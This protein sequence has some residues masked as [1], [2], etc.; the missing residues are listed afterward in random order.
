MT[1]YVL[2]IILL[3]HN[4]STPVVLTQEFSHPTLCEAAR[5][6]IVGRTRD[7]AAA[8]APRPRVLMADCLIRSVP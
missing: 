2:I 1:I 8:A 5:D 6:Y 3:G 7:P 4:T